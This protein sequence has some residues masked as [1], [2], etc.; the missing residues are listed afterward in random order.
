M[1]AEVAAVAVAVDKR[2]ASTLWSRKVG[3][4]YL[5]FFRLC[6]VLFDGEVYR[7]MNKSV[8]VGVKP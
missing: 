4:Q 7:R 6:V 1:S 5:R 3:A 2:K 8:V